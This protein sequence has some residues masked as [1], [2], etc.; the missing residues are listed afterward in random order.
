MCGEGS[1]QAPG[2]H[3]LLLLSHLSRPA[4]DFQGR[5]PCFGIAGQKLGLSTCVTPQLFLAPSKFFIQDRAN[6]LRVRRAADL[7]VGGMYICAEGRS[8][9]C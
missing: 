8:D 6:Y 3:C 7:N 2:G 9:H 5:A 1:D 4:A